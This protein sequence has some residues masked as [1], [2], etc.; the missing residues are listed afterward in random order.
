MEPDI[1]ARVAVDFTRAG[2]E[3]AAGIPRL[4]D[5]ERGERR[6]APACPGVSWPWPPEAVLSFAAATATGNVL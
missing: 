3:D 4:P 2:R 5:A 6:A 1:A